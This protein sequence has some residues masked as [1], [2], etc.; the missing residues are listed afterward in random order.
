MY[1]LLS[2]DGEEMTLINKKPTEKVGKIK[3][4]WIP[5]G[6]GLHCGD[7]SIDQVKGTMK[8]HRNDVIKATDEVLEIPDNYHK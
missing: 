4:Y 2:E 8:V 1:G 7:Y 5:D 6:A 3:I